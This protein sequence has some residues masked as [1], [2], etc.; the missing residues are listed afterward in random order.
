[1]PAPADF[2]FLAI[3]GGGLAAGA[4]L[5]LEALS[6]QTKLI[7][8]EPALA[9]SMSES[10]FAHQ[11]VTLSSIDSRIDSCI[12]SSINSSSF[13]QKIKLYPN[14]KNRSN[15]FLVQVKDNSTKNKDEKSIYKKFNKNIS[16]KNISK[17]KDG[18]E[19]AV[20]W[21]RVFI[22]LYRNLEWLNSF[23]E[24]NELA[25][26]KILKKFSKNFF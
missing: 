4:S 14:K 11:V 9:P 13:E 16:G 7:G 24:L 5:V 3:G 19:Y 10:L 25:M 23:A 26:H 17:I 18:F 2:M 8:V 20:N 12:N 22:D 15:S 1:L 21:K 6:P